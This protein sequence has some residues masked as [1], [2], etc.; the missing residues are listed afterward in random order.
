LFVVGVV[1][2]VGVAWTV[3]VP[4]GSVVGVNVTLEPAVLVDWRFWVSESIWL[5]FRA[6]TMM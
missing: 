6:L 3:G 1:F 4:F 5:E 2:V